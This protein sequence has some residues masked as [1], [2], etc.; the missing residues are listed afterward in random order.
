MQVKRY[1]MT[2]FLVFSPLYSKP[3]VSII[4]SVYKGDEFITLFLKNIVQQTIFD[5]CELILVNAHSPDNE[6]PIILEYCKQYPNI[7]YVRLDH[8]P[9]LY[10]VWNYAIRELAHGEFITNANIDDYRFPG[11]IEI[12]VSFLKRYPA[13]DLVYGDSFI[14]KNPYTE[15]FF[16]TEF[17]R[18]FMSNYHEFALTTMV[19]CLPGP[20]PLWRKSM[21]DTYGYFDETFFSSGD[22]EFWLR[23]VSQG[24]KFMKIPCIACIYYQN[25]NGLSTSPDEKKQQQRNKE[26]QYIHEH[27][28]HI[29][30]K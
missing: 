8:D 14:I 17:S 29:W 4:S 3:L 16:E 2:L 20:A 26:N 30:S 18:N 6:E 25:I 27:Y 10:A 12:Q 9:G 19:Y 28:S 22:H 15:T 7:V 21:H 11:S 24:A 1:L 13:I 5:Q 23:A